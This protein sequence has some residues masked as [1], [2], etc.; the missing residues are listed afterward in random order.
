M[1]S[2]YVKKAGKL[3]IKEYHLKEKVGT[4]KNY[5][6]HKNL[7]GRKRLTKQQTQQAFL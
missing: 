6:A 1:K 2:K 3:D 4:S 7:T 5:Y